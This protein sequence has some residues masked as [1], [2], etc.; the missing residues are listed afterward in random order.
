MKIMVAN[1]FYNDEEHENLIGVEC[2][3][4]GELIYF[5]DWDEEEPWLYCP[6]C[7]N[8]GEVDEY[9]DESTRIKAG[10][11]GEE[12]VPPLFLSKKKICFS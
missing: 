8:E 2:P 7:L 5:D 11:G 10:K 6:I 9:E 1:F 3:F 4:C 12:V